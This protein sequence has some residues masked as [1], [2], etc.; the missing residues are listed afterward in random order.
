MGHEHGMRRGREWGLGQVDEAR[1]A[2]T[3]YA[4]V[5]EYIHLRARASAANRER[6]GE[7]IYVD[8]NPMRNRSMQTTEIWTFFSAVR[9]CDRQGQEQ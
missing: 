7:A 6:G 4:S 5:L 9:V 8:E 3:I 1:D 2:S